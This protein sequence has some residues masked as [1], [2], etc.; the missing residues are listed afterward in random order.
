MTRPCLAHFA[1]VLAII[2]LISACG[3][4]DQLGSNHD[5]CHHH[6]HHHAASD[7]QHG[8]RHDHHHARPDD[9]TG[10]HYYY[11]HHRHRGLT[12]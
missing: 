8:R 6:D 11:Y 2:A 10:I 12:R 4:G 5:T 1:G 7:D 3:N 9:D